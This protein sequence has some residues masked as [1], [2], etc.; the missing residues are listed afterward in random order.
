MGNVTLRQVRENSFL[1][2]IILT[3]QC[4]IACKHCLF[5]CSPRREPK[6]M[7]TD[8]CVEYLR[9]FHKLGRETHL[10]GGE[11]FLFWERLIE[12]ARKAGDESVPIHCVET[13]GFWCVSDEITERRLGALK[14]A[15]VLGLKVSAD[16]YH[17]AFV[18]AKNLVRAARIGLE[19]FGQDNVDVGGYSPDPEYLE[20]LAGISAEEDKLR[21][22]V[23]NRPPRMTG[24]S[25]RQLAKYLDPV[26][27]D[28]MD[29]ERPWGNLAD[30]S[31][32]CERGWDL[33][34]EVHVDPYDNIQTNCGVILGNAK[35]RPLSEVVA[36]NVTAS[37]NP[38]IDALISRGVS[39]LLEVAKSKGYSPKDSYPQKCFL[40]CEARQYLRRFY[41]DTLGPDEVYF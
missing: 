12:I 40:C 1:G 3:Y 35:L 41:P 31:N 20:G 18:P 24:T 10:A 29:L 32:T 5:S 8:D 34:L 23:R 16:P 30:P 37:P 22:Y 28:Q 25:F 2:G 7:E 14:E 21:A 33:T 13:N 36:G 9:E 39:G 6:V 4:S 38:V 15:G 11:P 27:L 26:P 17:Q 19:I